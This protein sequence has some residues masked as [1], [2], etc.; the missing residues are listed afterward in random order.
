[1]GMVSVDRQTLREESVACQL[2]AADILL[3]HTKQSLWGW[4]IR[5]G[6]HCYWNHALLVCSPRDAEQGYGSISAVDAKTN[7][8]IVMN[9]VS[10]Y[11]NRSNK[12]DVAVKRLEADWFQD[13]GSTSTLDF[14]SYICNIALSEVDCRIGSRLMGFVDQIIR[15]LT[16]ILRFIRRKTRRICTSPSLPWN[17]RPIQVKAF[18]CG[19]FVQWCYYKGVSKLVEERGTGQSWL[20]EVIFN[21]RAKKEPTPFELLTATPADLANCDKLSWKYVIKEGV[22]RKVSSSEE[23]R[24]LTMPV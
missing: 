14:R 8:A 4:L 11:F 9:R 5:H 7:G 16:V 22:V 2:E 23:A 17:I 13:D 19:G 6:T 24:L 12:Y 1:M 18:T 3:I 21:P 20:E 15:Q 10:E